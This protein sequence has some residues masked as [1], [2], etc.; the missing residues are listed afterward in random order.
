MA[1]G[2]VRHFISPTCFILLGQCVCKP[3]P[4][5]QAWHGEFVFVLS[6]RCVGHDFSNKE[7]ESALVAS[8]KEP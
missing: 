5:L 8:F 4:L 3:F 6:G 1:R 7:W 2:R